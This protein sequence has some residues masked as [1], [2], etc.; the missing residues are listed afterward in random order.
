MLRIP[1][2]LTAGADG[3]HDIDIVKEPEL[4]DTIAIGITDCLSSNQLADNA[5]SA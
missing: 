2:S 5:F 4:R 1:P 3:S